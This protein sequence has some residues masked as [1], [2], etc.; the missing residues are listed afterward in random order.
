[1]SEQEESYMVDW[2]K[3]VFPPP[4]E[5]STT[6]NLGDGIGV[7]SIRKAASYEP[8]RSKAT[9]FFSDEESDTE[10]ESRDN[11][12]GGAPLSH[13]TMS[14]ERMPFSSAPS[15]T[16][17]PIF[18]NRK[19]S[20]SSD[21]R[22]DGF[23]IE[24]SY[25][26]GGRSPLAAFQGRGV[27]FRPNKEVVM[28]S[29]KPPRVD[30][31]SLYPATACIFVA[32]LEARASD[33]E[34][35]L[36]L[37]KA[38]SRFG[39]VFVK[40]RRDGHR[41]M[42]YAFCQ[43]TNDEDA[44]DALE[45]AQGTSLLGRLLRIEMAKANLDFLVIKRSGNDISP[46]EAVNLLQCLREIAR[47]VRLERNI[48]L[49]LGC[50]PGIV[51]T[52][53]MFDPKREVVQTFASDRVYRVTS[54][55]RKLFTTG[56]APIVSS[57]IQKDKDLMDLYDKDRRSVF[58]GNLPAYYP[59]E[60]L[61]RHAARCGIVASVAIHNKGNPFNSSVNCFAFVEFARP[62]SV[63]AMIKYFN[64]QSF[65]GE[66]ALKVKRKLSRTFETPRRP[67]G[68]NGGS[69]TSQYPNSSL[70]RRANGS[71]YGMRGAFRSQERFSG[72]T[73]IGDADNGVCPP[74]GPRSMLHLDPAPRIGPLTRSEASGD[75]MRKTKLPVASKIEASIKEE[76]ESP[77]SSSSASHSAPSSGPFSMDHR[78]SGPN[79]NGNHFAPPMPPPP[80][81]APPGM[82]MPW[83]GPYNPFGYPPQYPPYMTP[84]ATPGAY[85][86]AMMGPSM[87]GPGYHD[88]YAVPY[89]MPA[90]AS[91]PAE[92]KENG[93]APTNGKEVKSAVKASDKSKGKAQAQQN[94]SVKS[95]SAKSQ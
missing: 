14:P 8:Q 31:Q 23:V 48:Q 51:I 29:A 71:L 10:V 15:P 6:S 39:S 34:L 57:Q 41:E 70:V 33:D 73:P 80:V 63:D 95:E 40:I 74:T 36:A 37:T 62:D 26:G 69:G 66:R 43:Y 1:M 84:Q 42:P 64:N 68:L 4:G 88:P 27:C 61:I 35:E 79:T 56:G 25:T 90:P 32:N 16:K 55:D 22:S 49:S 20:S 85:Y 11:S 46:N 67:H 83:A 87:F 58:I 28:V 65:D 30:A 94:G 72:L 76:T 17:L 93:H 81:M 47:A 13:A 18:S 82:A 3:P 44:Q 52:Y 78:A 12:P 89:F 86:G 59:E 9:E 91:M 77:S 75:A 50:S 54:F 24:P 19:N 45:A 38:F 21:G 53:K 5:S 2:R 7:I 60:D 92:K